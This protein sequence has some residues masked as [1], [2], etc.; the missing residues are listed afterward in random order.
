[1]VIHKT[2]QSF[3]SLK[4]LLIPSSFLRTSRRS[5]LPF[6]HPSRE[7]RWHG[8]KTALRRE[9]KISAPRQTDTII[10]PSAVTRVLNFYERGTPNLGTASLFP[11]GFEEPGPSGRLE[12]NSHPSQPLRVESM[13][14]RM[15]GSVGQAGCKISVAVQSK[16]LEDVPLLWGPSLIS[17]LPRLRRCPETGASCSDS[18]DSSVASWLTSSSSSPFPNQAINCTSQRPVHPLLVRLIEIAADLC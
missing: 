9:R 7:G 17:S 12:C 13:M 2:E 6:P 18:L 14:G 11:S 4:S 10:T 1:M 15:R 5:F 16:G 8:S 3:L